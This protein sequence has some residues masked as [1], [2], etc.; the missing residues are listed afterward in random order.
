MKHAYNYMD[1]F[2]VISNYRYDELHVYTVE[3]YQIKKKSPLQVNANELRW[4]PTPTFNC[5]MQVIGHTL[6]DD[7][8]CETPY[9]DS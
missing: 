4:I 6:P 8:G 5:S 9:F 7:T 1:L 3:E 2:T